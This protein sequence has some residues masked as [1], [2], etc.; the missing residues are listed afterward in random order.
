MSE[1]Q[2]SNFRIGTFTS[3]HIQA[4]E[5]LGRNHVHYLAEESI[6]IWGEFDSKGRPI[7]YKAD[8]LINDANYSSGV[9]EIDGE[10][11]TKL[12]HE[13][14]DAKRD[15]RLRKQGLWVEHVLNGEVYFIMDILE[16][17]ARPR[18]DYS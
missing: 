9:I 1:R 10:I 3:A 11:H 2:A 18:D 17:H 13:I 4:L 12:K 14:K 7:V 16:K 5:I 6:S 15:E 8:I